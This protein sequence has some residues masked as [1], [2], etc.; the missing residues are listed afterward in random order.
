MVFVIIKA[1]TTPMLTELPVPSKLNAWLT[2]PAPSVAPPWS[3]PLLP[4]ITSFAL[5][6]PGYQ[7]T[8]PLPGENASTFVVP[9][10]P[11]LYPETAY[12]L[13]PT[14]AAPNSARGVIIEGADDHVLVVGS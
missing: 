3:V 10:K 2:L 14:A 5:P 4:P 6:L 7:A 13:P 1:G 11:T 9:G 8:M 12:S